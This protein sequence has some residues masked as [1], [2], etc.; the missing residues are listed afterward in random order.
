MHDAVAFGRVQAGL[1][2]A[3]SV[4]VPGS[5]VPHV[6]IALPSY[7][8]DENLLAHYAERIPW[9]EHRYLV[10]MFL[11]NTI[12]GVRLVF[13]GSLHPGE[14]VL[15]HYRAMLR[16]GVGSDRFHVV[17]A[18][19]GDAR[20][21]AA[22]VLASPR[23]LA[24]IRE[25]VGTL[26]AVI[27]PW[28]VD[29]AEADLAT[30]LGIPIDGSHPDLLPLAFKSAGKRLAREA[31]VPVAFGV[32]DVC[33]EDGVVRAALHVLAERPDAPGVVVKLDDSGAGDG[34]RVLRVAGLPSDP[35]EREAELRRRVT[36]WPEWYRTDLRRGCVVE[37]LVAGAD[38]S[39]PSVQVVV[40]PDH[41]VEVL[42]THEQ[43]LGGEDGQVYQGCRFPARGEYAAL[44][45]RH[46]EA[47]ARVLAARGAVGRIGIDFMCWR[48]A[49]DWRAVALEI[50]LRKGGTTHPFTAL[51][52]LTGGRYDATRGRFVL[53]DGTERSY[54][55]S[56]NLIDAAWRCL[57]G[58][59]ALEAV[60]RAGLR[61]D[62]VA[63]TGVVLLMVGGL[64]L[65][66]RCGIVAIGHDLEHAARLRDAARAALDAAAAAAMT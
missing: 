66:G 28:N 47:M 31:G 3:L 39:S 30:E 15:D 58:T 27:E 46:A 38:V 12:P 64:H 19:A 4:D 42:S 1:G 17:A 9:L 55:A 45:A 40:R 32:E 49:G 26:P 24:E 8:L 63:R 43:E 33:T 37:E 54:V 41:S 2:A 6:V 21:V 52:H 11:L 36:A 16:P 57:T 35:S 13:V 50:N 25:L 60:A 20:P 48:A 34:N 51:R 65:D 62:P 56:D 7:S 23:A 29:A 5:A 14:D 53:D 10:A 59:P 22:K 44:I 18:G 61:F